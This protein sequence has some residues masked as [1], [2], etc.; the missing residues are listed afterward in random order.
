[1]DEWSVRIEWISKQERGDLAPAAD[2]GLAETQSPQAPP[3]SVQ[4]VESKRED[5]Y[6]CVISG[7]RYGVPA[8]Q[9][10]KIDSVSSKK[11]KKI[12]GKG[13]ATLADFKPIFKSIKSG[14]LGPWGDLP[15]EV[16]KEYRFV[17]I[18]H[19]ALGVADSSATARSIMLVS[20]GRNQG[21]LLLESSGAELR[22]GVEILMGRSGET[23]VLGMADAETD[24]P[25]EVLNLEGVF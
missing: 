11:V 13:Y 23:T 10:V 3:D 9:V 20:G 2:T 15:V 22:K 1:M 25:V 19:Q 16:L 4:E 5:V 24:A 6:Y 14:L 17:P 7:K 12:I 8:S 18:S 21:F